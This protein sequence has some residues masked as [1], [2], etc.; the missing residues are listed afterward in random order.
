MLQ[1]F[2]SSRLLACAAMIGCTVAASGAQAATGSASIG[3]LTLSFIDLDPNDGMEAGFSFAEQSGRLGVRGN[4]ASESK[5]LAGWD[6]IDQLRIEDVN[7]VAEARSGVGTQS[8]FFSALEGSGATALAET[9][10]GGTLS[11]RPNTQVTFSGSLS[12]AIQVD[13]ACA[14]TDACNG[15]LS[16]AFLQLVTRSGPE[17]G[18]QSLVAVYDN[19]DPSRSMLSQSKSEALDVSVSTGAGAEDFFVTLGTTSFG[20]GIKLPPPPP[21]PPIPEPETYALM[22][23]GIA[24]VGAGCRKRLGGGQQ[25]R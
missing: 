18:S 7:F 5:D 4:S 17:V 20:S 12:A 9:I 10:W 21:P 23:M 19:D 6:V 8:S 3:N 13:A 16:A 15:Q 24:L 14:S 25:R 2:R 11:V 1:R 22:L